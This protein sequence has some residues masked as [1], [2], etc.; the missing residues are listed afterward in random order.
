HIV[1]DAPP[2]YRNWCDTHADPRLAVRVLHRKQLTRARSSL[3]RAN[4]LGFHRIDQRLSGSPQA[5]AET[6]AQ[7]G[8]TASQT[9]AVSERQTLAG[10]QERQRAIVA[11]LAGGAKARPVSGIERSDAIGERRGDEDSSIC[12]MCPPT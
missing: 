12:E 11:W 6:G 2:A 3:R 7:V 10:E 1:A 5:L 9:A 8:Y 4:I